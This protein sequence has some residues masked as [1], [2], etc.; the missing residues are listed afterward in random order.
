MLRDFSP[1]NNDKEYILYD[2]D[3][4]FV[5]ILLKEIIDYILE[6]MYVD[7]IMKA[8]QNGTSEIL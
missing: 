3:S 6:E 4:L 7:R 1:L 5:N 2:V 8:F